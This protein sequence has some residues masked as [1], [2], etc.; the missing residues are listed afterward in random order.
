MGVTFPYTPVA[1]RGGVV[2]KPYLWVVLRHQGNFTPPINMLLDTGADCCIFDAALATDLLRFDVAALGRAT[3]ISGIEGPVPAY[4]HPIEVH[5][6]DLKRTFQIPE[7]HFCQLRGLAGVL[8]HNGF[9]DRLIVRFSLGR[10]FEIEDGA[11][12]GTRGT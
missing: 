9:L 7:A 11:A 6:R 2:R 8:G 12:T 3:T 1:S 5:V 10:S 4:V